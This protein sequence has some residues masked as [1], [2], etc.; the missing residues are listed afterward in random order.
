MWKTSIGTGS[1]LLSEFENI[2][3]KKR[4]KKINFM[5]GKEPTQ[6]V[7]ILSFFAWLKYDVYHK[8]ISKN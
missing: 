6:A 8:W 1:P 5:L 3:T 4:E 7:T 2:L